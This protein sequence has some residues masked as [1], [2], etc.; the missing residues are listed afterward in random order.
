ML[1]KAD[2]SSFVLL[3]LLF[4]LTLTDPPRTGTSRTPCCFPPFACTPVGLGFK[5]GET[6]IRDGSGAQACWRNHGAP[7]IYT[8]LP[9]H[10]GRTD[11]SAGNGAVKQESG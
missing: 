9:P 6:V 3:S 11:V 4:V 1:P 2:S 5:V 10:C 8:P 7:V